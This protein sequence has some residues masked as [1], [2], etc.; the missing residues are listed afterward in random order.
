M[1]ITLEAMD[2]AETGGSGGMGLAVAVAPVTVG[3]SGCQIGSNFGDKTATPAGTGA[4]TGIAG[5]VAG[6][7][8]VPVTS[9]GS[10]VGGK[11][12]G[13]GKLG[14]GAEGPSPRHL[15]ERKPG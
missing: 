14:E 13:L 3:V 9:T 11:A 8:V 7:P 5:S 1:T 4:A 15:N 10:G 12:E 6:P 2:P